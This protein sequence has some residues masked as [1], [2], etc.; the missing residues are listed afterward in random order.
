MNRTTHLLAASPLTPRRRLTQL[1][2]AALL[3]AA[4]LAAAPA[5]Q[6]AMIDFE[7]LGTGTVGHN[8]YF[9]QAGFYIAGYSNDPDAIDGDLVGAVI[10]GTD[11]GSCAV[12]QC[13]SHDNSYY[14]AVNDGVLDLTRV[15]QNQTFS[16]QSFDASFLGS[17]PGASYPG[18]SGLLRVQGF[19]ANGSSAYEDF[20]LDG[21][22][23][24]GFEFGHYTASAGFGSQ[25]F[26]EVAFFGF[27]C[28]SGGDC[29]AFQS[30]K[31][32]F[33]IDN[34]SAMPVPEPTTWMM[35]G[36]GLLALAARRRRQA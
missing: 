14:A 35:M 9:Q 32:Q 26:V 5:A 34:I 27:S 33:A 36:A 30:D 31:G 7:H 4:A 17:S 23:A 16:V 8:E 19:R 11:P 12:L 18:V 28:D 20:A 1:V 24:N 22:G 21:P 10:D 25:Q 13:P 6:A 15:Q 2:G 29:I 3:G